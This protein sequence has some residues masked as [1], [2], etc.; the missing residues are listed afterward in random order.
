MLNL[1][2][3]WATATR[4]DGVRNELVSNQLIGVCYRV[5]EEHFTIVIC[6]RDGGKIGEKSLRCV[7]GVCFYGQ[8]NL[9]RR[10]PGRRER[11]RL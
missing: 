5:P 7:N 4:Q 3:S 9:L 2:K 11:F 1:P 10:Q 6:N 8:E